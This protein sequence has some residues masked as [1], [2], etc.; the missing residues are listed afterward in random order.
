MKYTITDAR[1]PGWKMITYENKSRRYISPWDLSVGDSTYRKFYKRYVDSGIMPK[2][3]ELPSTARVFGSE[4]TEPKQAQENIP[5][6][7]YVSS[8][9]GQPAID[10]NSMA[11]PE[12]LLPFD[13]PEAKPK[14]GRSTAKAANSKEL[15]TAL[16][17][18]ILISTSVV[19]MAVSIP[20]ITA[21]ETEAKA[22]A[23]PL[24]NLLEPTDFNRKFGRYIVGTNDYGL[25]GY[26][27]YAY[28]YRVSSAIKEKR[29]AVPRPGQVAQPNSS[30]ANSSSGKPISGAGISNG[31][32]PLKFSS[33]GIRGFTPI[34]GTP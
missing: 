5:S 14:T 23:I 21:T 20:D 7:S 2:R 16:Q 24:A 32:A 13:V 29:N 6:F 8:T 19:A 1:I 3:E 22:I 26:A 11:E 15:S 34:T 4:D 27:L 10:N 25:L 12:E 33:D 31:A 9:S 28:L 17:F 18:L 30:T